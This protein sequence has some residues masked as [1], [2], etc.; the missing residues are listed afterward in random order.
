MVTEPVKH[1]E[2]YNDNCNWCD[3]PIY[4]DHDM[5]QPGSQMCENCAINWL[6]S[7]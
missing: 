5:L 7:H 3:D 4:V 1:R 2:E 6:E